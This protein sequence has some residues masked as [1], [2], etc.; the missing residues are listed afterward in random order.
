MQNSASFVFLHVVVAGAARKPLGSFVR[1]LYSV[2]VFKLVVTGRIARCSWYHP[3]L[4]MLLM[5]PALLVL[6]YSRP[7][8]RCPTSLPSSPPPT[9][10]STHVCLLQ[11]LLLLLLLGYCC[12]QSCQGFPTIAEE[13]PLPVRLPHQ[14]WRSGTYIH[15]YLREPP[16]WPRLRQGVCDV[17]PV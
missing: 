3:L 7:L 11:L 17:F 10:L 13:K 6:G 9:P 1:C 16:Q 4:L 12:L 2:F 5:L 8:T 14:P 15:T